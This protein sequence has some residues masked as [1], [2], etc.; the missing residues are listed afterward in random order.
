MQTTNWECLVAKFFQ[1]VSFNR[2]SV[3]V[4]FIIVCRSQGT[5]EF[6]AKLLTGIICL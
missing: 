5:A 4:S 1:P 2:I 3:K 6:D